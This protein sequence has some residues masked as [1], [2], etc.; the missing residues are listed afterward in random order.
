[1]KMPCVLRLI[2]A[3]AVTLVPQR[4][5]PQQHGF[6]VASVKPNVLG[7]AAGPPRVAADGRRFSASNATLRSFITFAYRPDDGRT[8]QFADV[9]GAPE[10]MDRDRFDIEAKTDEASDPAS[11]VQMRRMVQSLLADRFGLKTHWETHENVD[12]YNLVLA[13]GGSKLKLSEDQSTPSIPVITPGP[14]NASQPPPRGQIRTI[15]NPAAGGITVTVS[16]SSVPFADVAG[17]LQSYARRAVV[18]KTGLNGLFDYRLQFVLDA[19]SSTNPT[20]SDPAGS[21]LFTAIQEQL[22][23]K[24]EASKGAVQVLVIDSIRKPSDN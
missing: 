24:L 23:L 13:K 15:A 19:G 11:S 12:I 2:I 5:L 16:A 17:T 10:W 9:I 21:S 18:D 7:N 20:A 22:G 14:A 4:V 6:D 3:A 8:L 1:M